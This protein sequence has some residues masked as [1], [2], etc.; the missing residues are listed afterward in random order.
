M[1]YRYEFYEA[2]YLKAFLEK[3]DVEVSIKKRKHPNSDVYAFYSVN[4]QDLIVEYKR[5]IQPHNV[6]D[7]IAKLKSYGKD[8]ALM[9]VSDYITPSAKSMLKEKEINYLDQA[10]NIYLKLGQFLIFI[11]GE[12]NASPSEQ[13]KYQHRAF[14]KTGAAVVFQFLMD[15]EL[16]NAPQRRIA[17][18]SNVSLG[19]IPKVFNQ[20]EAENYIIRLDGKK[21]KLINSKGLLEKWVSVFNDKLLP[22]LHLQNCRFNK[23]NEKDFFRQAKLKGDTQW[24][25]EPAAARLTNYLL[26]EK[27]TVFSELT[28]P[29]LA[30]NYRLLPDGNGSIV[31]Y[32]KFWNHT[33]ANNDTVHALIVYAQLLGDGDSR[34]LE[35]AEIIYKQYIEPKL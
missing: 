18:F 21:R 10:G 8:E 7:I 11:E 32:Q 1:G 6:L 23:G 15:H 35:T 30:K 27:I 33:T 17:E 31:V 4:N 29:K 24:G 34:N 3:L 20:L 14:T 12:K 5:Q 16:V 22:S 13:E 9:V 19:T 28:K 26:P 2:D 25:G